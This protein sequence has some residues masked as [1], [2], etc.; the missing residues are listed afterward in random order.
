V[1]STISKG[2]ISFGLVSIPIRRFAAARSKRAYLHKAHSASNTRLKQPLCGP[3][4]DRI[5]DRSERF[6]PQSS[7]GSKRIYLALKTRAGCG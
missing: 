4:C 2:T 3:T 5:V 7:L 6:F 1:A